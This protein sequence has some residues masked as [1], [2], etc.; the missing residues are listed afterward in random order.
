MMRGAL[1]R[2]RAPLS[3]DKLIPFVVEPGLCVAQLT[4][5][6]DQAERRPAATGTR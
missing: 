6:E 5:R 3:A 4:A 1:T 2:L